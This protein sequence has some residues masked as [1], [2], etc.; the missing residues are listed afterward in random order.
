[1]KLNPMKCSFDNPTGELLGY[2]VSARG[3]EANPEKIQA[4]L[5]MKKPTKLKEI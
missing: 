2:L 4:I 3:I 5:T 1:M